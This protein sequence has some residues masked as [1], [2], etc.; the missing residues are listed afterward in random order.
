[1]LRACGQLPETSCSAAS[2]GG[3]CN[4]MWPQPL[5][6]LGDRLAQLGTHLKQPGKVKAGQLTPLMGLLSLC[7]S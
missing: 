1:M 2:A 5:G 6:L 7:E 3:P 4:T